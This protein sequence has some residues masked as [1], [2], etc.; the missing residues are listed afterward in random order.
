[1]KSLIN[2]KDV[3]ALRTEFEENGVVLL[4]DAFDQEFCDNAKSFIDSW[5]GEKDLL[6]KGTEIRIWDAQN[7]KD[8][9][10]EFYKSCHKTIEDLF[11]KS[12]N[13]YT[14]LAIRNLPIPPKDDE[15]QMGRWHL[16][17]F[18]EQ[19]KIFLFLTDTSEESGPFE[20]VP[21]SH[22]TTFKYKNLLSGKYI[23]VS[24]IFKKTRSYQSLNEGWIES[25][26]K[27]G[28][29]S[30]AVICKAGTAM[31]VN[32][33]AIHRA[34]PCRAGSRYALTAYYY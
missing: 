2:G 15:V 7:K 4:P 31:I 16:D 27:Q 26:E 24:D 8:L 21:G 5:D 14:L 20:F 30:K 33:S 22:E 29:P 13:P 18:C 17:S 32:T 10:G 34:R 1:M 19:V 11:E 28:M 3:P 12:H 6:Y 25:L 23:T 9:L